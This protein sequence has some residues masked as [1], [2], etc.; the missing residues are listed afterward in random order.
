M[1][2]RDKIVEELADFVGISR[3]FSGQTW[4]KTNR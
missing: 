2:F 3:E 1:T 4:L